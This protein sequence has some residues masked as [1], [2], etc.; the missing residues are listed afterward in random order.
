MR[1]YALDTETYYDKECS[2]VT[3]GVQHYC[4]HPDFECYMVTICGD[5]GF[6]Y[7][8]SPEGLDWSKISGEGTRWLSH[9]M[10]FDGAVVDWMR[11]VGHIPAD[12][13]PQE[14]FCTADLCAWFGLPRSLAGAAELLLGIKPDKTVRDKMKGRKHRDLDESDAQ[15]LANYAMED[16]R[17]CLKLWD[18]LAAGHPVLSEGRPYPEVDRRLSAYTAQMG[19]YGVPVNLEKIESAIRN[20]KDRIWQAEQEIPWADGDKPILSPK[21]L[22]LEC[23]KVGIVPPRSLA[24]DSEECAAWEDKYGDIY[25][26]I[27]AMRTWRRCNAL[28]KKLITMRSRV[29]ADGRM[30]YDLKFCGAHT[31]R[32]SG[33]GG[34]N[35]QNLPRKE[36]FGV[37]FRGLIEAPEGNSFV[38]VDLAQIE[39][40]C[41][42]WLAGDESMLDAV[43]SGYGIYE[44]FAKANNMATFEPGTLKHVNAPVYQTAKAMALG[45]GYGVG[46]VKFSFT[47]P[48]LTGGA[49]APTMTEAETVVNKYRENNPRITGLWRKLESGARSCILRDFTVELPSSNLLRYRKLTSLGGITAEIMRSGRYVRSKIYG[50]LLAENLTQAVARDVFAD[51]WVRILDRGVRIVMT[52]HD[53]LVAECKDQDAEAVLKIMLEEMHIAPDW[54]PGLPVAAEGQITKRYEK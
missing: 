22:A 25:G 45:C 35:M 15:E 4:R 41:L 2:V 7:V 18:R 9:N 1:T 52:V 12:A 6:E 29:K 37:D 3:M 38:I 42:H 40:R 53:E 20:L 19:W 33:G 17:L 27:S 14:W 34:I 46:A 23:G 5:D 26:W 49:Y 48:L 43:R 31:R 13:R 24:Q 51:M 39:P 10:S 30:A 21:Q 16:A 54:A 11:E 36:M 50:G 32:W 47:A 8:G 44:A 28:M